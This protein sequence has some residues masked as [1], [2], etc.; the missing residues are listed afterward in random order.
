MAYQYPE[1]RK[2]SGLYLQAN[3]FDVPD[4]AM[5]VAR[6]IEIQDDAT[7]QKTRGWYTYWDP[8]L[9]VE[10][11]GIVTFDD[12][13]I[14]FGA[15]AAYYFVDDTS[16]DPY[17]PV[18]F[19]FN[20]QGSYSISL[21]YTTRTQEQNQNL[22][23]TTDGGI[24][25]LETYSGPVQKAGVPPALDLKGS[26]GNSATGPLPAD[27]NTGYRIVFGRRDSNGNLLLGSPS[28]VA[29]VSV[30]ADGTGLAYTRSGAGPWTV[31]VV[32]DPST[33][34][35][36]G[37]QVIISA[38]T[39]PDVNGT[40]TITAIPT[41]NSI[42]FS[43]AADPGAVGTL[44]MSF[45]RDANLEASIPSEIDDA[46]YNW[47]YQVYRSSSSDGLAV[48]PSPDFKLVGETLLTQA[49]LNLGYVI[50]NDD[51]DPLL[52][53]AELYTNPNTREGELQANARPPKAED[54]QLYKG[55][56]LYANI[57]TRARLALQLI[58]T[59]D[60]SSSSNVISFFATAITEHYRSFVAGVGNRTV[61]A[62]SVAG[63][64]TVTITYASHGASNGWTVELVSV[65]GSVPRGTYTVS[66]VTANTFDIT[67]TGNTASAIDFYFV[68]NGSEPIFF[69]DTVS[70][71]LAVQIANSA[72]Y[73]VKAINR[74]SAILYANYSST[75]DESP[76][77]IRF[78]TKGFLLFT[79]YIK[80]SVAG[81][82]PFLTPLPN[83]F[84]TG[85]QVSFEKDVLPNAIMVSKINEPEAVPVLQFFPAGAEN[86]DIKRIFTLRDSEVILKEDGIFRMSGDTINDFQITVIDATV[87]CLSSVGACALNNLVH[88]ISNQGLIQISEN[89]V[90]IISRRID[91]VIQPLLVAPTAMEIA[92]AAGFETQRS[93]YFSVPSN[94]NG[95]APVTYIYNVLNECWFD[96]PRI[97]RNMCVGPSDTAF[98]ILGEEANL[99]LRQRKS[100]NATDY[101]D[102][103]SVC[104]VTA[105]STGSTTAGVL[106][107]GGTPRVPA[108]GDVILYNSALNRIV[109][110]TPSPGIY[111]VTFMDGTNIPT[112]ATECIMYEAFQ[113]I[114]KFSPFHAGQVGREKF[115]AQIQ[116]HLRQ[117]VITNLLIQFSTETYVDSGNTDWD[118]TNVSGALQGWGYEP[119][120]L[121]PWG[122]TESI[123]LRAGTL[124]SMI[125]R[126]LVPF[127][128]A[129]STFIQAKF[130]HSE[131][132]EPMLMQAVSWSVRG[133]GERVTR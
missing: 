126:T 88:T 46:S 112:S 96:T 53:G 59:L 84:S 108:V 132:A 109:A 22:Y 78:E 65:T 123:T 117:P 125:I 19:K 102:N 128:A 58:S 52:V 80:Q 95:I 37:Q 124:P 60:L 20:I 29:Y 76:G 114:V 17:S 104:S 57:T 55:Y 118:T 54:I 3:S 30:P 27:S 72:Y 4:G 51:V 50:F 92:C 115:F 71:S 39:D 107:T 81:V 56:M 36:V 79:V 97:F 93:F 16:Y 48:S 24:C 42:A 14:A 35:R 87:H 68:T 43:V 83:S 106:V 70:S 77:K 49:D 10:L 34:Y 44:T 98:A 61:S 23:F 130:T 86:Q 18:G 121:F 41:A 2:F 1:I 133:Y 6:N 131:A 28:D 25:K 111:L 64:T 11:K 66:G 67:S 73:L 100:G 47:F 89:S 103:F 21:S 9:G 7:I 127:Y 82:Q 74:S 45:A 63:V 26:T 31:T 120:G 32:I 116:F 105:T 33:G 90:K 99:L 129:R 122:M 94:I 40:Q 12:V 13:L 62:T 15:T 8:P 91:D 119:W 101:S 75:F 113:S 5:E 85:V 110:V 38:G 69:V